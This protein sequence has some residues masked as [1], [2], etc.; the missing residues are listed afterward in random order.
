MSVLTYITRAE[1]T[2][3][4]NSFIKP[5]Y[6]YCPAVLLQQGYATMTMTLAKA[7]GAVHVSV[8]LMWPDHFPFAILIKTPLTSLSKSAAD[9]NNELTNK[10]SN[11]IR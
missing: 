7:H 3:P 10:L 9:K 2:Q 11:E 5:A 4:F 6:S 1:I 8:R